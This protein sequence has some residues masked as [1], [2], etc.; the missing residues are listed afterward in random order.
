MGTAGMVCFAG[1]LGWPLNFP[2][3][4]WEGPRDRH[5]SPTHVSPL[6]CK[7]ELCPHCPCSQGTHGFIGHV[8]GQLRGRWK[9]TVCPH[10]GTVGDCQPAGLI[11]SCSWEKHCQMGTSWAPP[12]AGSKSGREPLRGSE[13]PVPVLGAQ[14]SGLHVL[15]KDKAQGTGGPRQ[16]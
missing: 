16:A 1:A 3:S 12:T 2:I 11:S 14:A 8:R 15:L 13:P 6:K 9:G 5:L 4:N 10:K 7:L